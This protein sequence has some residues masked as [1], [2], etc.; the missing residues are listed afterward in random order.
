VQDWNVVVTVF[1]GGYRRALRALRELGPVE[2]SPYH[3]VLVMKV[4]DPLALLDAVEARTRETPALYD[5][6]SRVAPAQRAFDFNTADEF[7]A[8]ADD[9]VREWSLRLAGCSCHV[10]LH[11]RG[12]QHTLATQ[13]MERRLDGTI[14]DA[15]ASAGRPARISFEGADAVIGIDVIDARAGLGLWRREDFARYRMLRPD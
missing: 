3:N 13:E 6:I 1:Q 4:I 2:R 7:L 11:L 10:R 8:T 12:L 14:L 9:I 15:T 5:A